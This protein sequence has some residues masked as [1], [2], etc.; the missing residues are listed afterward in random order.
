METACVRCSTK[1]TQASHPMAHFLVIC[2]ECSN[3]S[4]ENIYDQNNYHIKLWEIK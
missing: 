4:E 1:F 2:H 3:K